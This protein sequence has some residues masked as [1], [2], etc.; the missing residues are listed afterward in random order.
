[1]AVLPA[2]GEGAF[3]AETVY[4]GLATIADSKVVDV[5]TAAA[6]EHL[7]VAEAQRYSHSFGSVY[8]G[9]TQNRYSVPLG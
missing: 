1:M 6:V 2:T 9:Y 4:F 3:V 8:S 7:L 5:E